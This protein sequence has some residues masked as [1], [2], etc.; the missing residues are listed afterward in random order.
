MLLYS[1]NQIVLNIIQDIGKTHKFSKYMYVEKINRIAIKR[2]YINVWRDGKEIRGLSAIS[3]T[4]T[5]KHLIWR[6]LKIHIHIHTC[7]FKMLFYLDFTHLDISRLFSTLHLCSYVHEC[8]CKIIFTNLCTCN[9][10]WLSQPL[11]EYAAL[12]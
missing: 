9:T 8:V 11:Y 1:T 2:Q 12:F 4:Q 3:Y 10:S 6:V 7:T 5:Y